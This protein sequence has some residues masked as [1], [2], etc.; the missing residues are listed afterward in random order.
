[1]KTVTIAHKTVGEGSPVFIIAEAGCNHN[2]DINLAKKLVDVA[3]E[4]GADAV[5]FQT[6][7]TDELVTQQ[8]EKAS[9]Q[10]ENTGNANESQY[11]M[12]KRL[13]LSFDSF[14]TLKGYC[15]H[16][17]IIFLSTPYDYRSADF[18]DELEIP[19]FKIASGEITNVPFLSYI[20]RKKKPL[21][22]ST[23]MST[24][25][26]VQDALKVIQ[27]TPQTPPVILLHCTSAYPSR[28]EDANLRAMHTLHHRFQLPVGL[29]DHTRGSEIPLAAVALGAS[30]LEKH[31]T[32]DKNSPGPDHFLSLDPEEL[33]RL[34]QS[35]RSVE[36]ALGDG[37]KAPVESE[38]HIKKIARKSI[39]AAT[40]I[41]KGE[42]FSEHNLTVKRPGNGM[43]P[44]RWNDVLGKRAERNFK[45]DELI[46]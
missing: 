41:K 25:E 5:K 42:P 39:V 3:V 29:S 34:V 17:D 35:I 30:I 19:A 36:K 38:K 32:L 40:N 1:M 9:Y 22:L 37:I 8:A 28:P 7:I 6:F 45:A 26:E 12:L 46:E 10:K 44:A 11:A 43:S 18:L 13:E 14:K 2:G 4:A 24:E 33:R 20:A 16:K 31:F 27:E 23:G 15:E 21:I